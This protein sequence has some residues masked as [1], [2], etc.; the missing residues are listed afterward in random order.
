MLSNETLYA[1]RRSPRL[2]TE[3]VVQ[4]G[5]LIAVAEPGLDTSVREQWNDHRGK[6]HEEIFS[7]KRVLGR[8]SGAVHRACR[9][10]NAGRRSRLI[11]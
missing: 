1:R 5:T 9:P 6:E 7:K 10:C 2:Q 4:L 3:Q 8:V 11:R